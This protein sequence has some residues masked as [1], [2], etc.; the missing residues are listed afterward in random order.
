MPPGAVA[1]NIAAAAGGTRRPDGVALEV[2]GAVPVAKASAEARGVVALVEPA[3]EGAVGELL[4]EFV[5]AWRSESIEALAALLTADAGPLDARSRG[6][7][8]LVESWR[9]RLRAH[10][11]AKLEGTEVLRADRVERWT[12][13]ELGAVGSPARPPEMLS[14]ELLVRAPLEVTRIGNEKVFGDVMEMLLRTEEGRLRIAAYL[15]VDAP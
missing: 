12:E 14:G 2:R 13:G 11:Y 3:P 9:A 4:R 7:T 5:D 6:R 1:S 10:P 15:E 8:A